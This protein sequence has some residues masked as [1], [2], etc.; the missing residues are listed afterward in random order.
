MAAEAAQST[1]TQ[2]AFLKQQMEFLGAMKD[3]LLSRLHAPG[4]ASTIKIA[5]TVEWPTLHESDSDVKEL[6]QQFKDTAKLANDGKGMEW[7]EMLQN[8]PSRLHG[9]R[10]KYAKLI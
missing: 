4:R 10:L 9:S 7:R 6:F 3:T 8:L 5:P 1:G 2:E